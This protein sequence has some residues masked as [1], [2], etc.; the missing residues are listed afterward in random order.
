MNITER[1]CISF[2]LFTSLS[3][4]TYETLYCMY[5]HTLMTVTRNLFSSSSCIAPLMEPMAQ[6]N[7]NKQTHTQSNM[8]SQEVKRL[9]SMDMEFQKENEDCQHYTPL[10]NFLLRDMCE[11]WATAACTPT[12]TNIDDA[13]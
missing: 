4:S 5:V 3:T 10:R 2:P 8:W 11:W 13:V 6:H 1:K 7:C 12:N 9:I